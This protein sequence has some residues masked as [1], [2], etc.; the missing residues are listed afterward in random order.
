MARGTVQIGGK[1]HATLTN[2]CDHRKCS[3]IS[4]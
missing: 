2:I 3:D 4:F 1:S